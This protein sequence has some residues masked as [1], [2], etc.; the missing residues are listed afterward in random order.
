MI[1]YKKHKITFFNIIIGLIAYLSFSINM[2]LAFYFNSQGTKYIGNNEK[3]FWHYMSLN[4]ISLN[5]ALIS[6][7]I[8]IILIIFILL[9][10]LI[11]SAIKQNKNTNTN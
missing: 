8:G 6:I 1:D 10:G 7:T 4:S 11:F 3:L 5:N 9:I 2:V